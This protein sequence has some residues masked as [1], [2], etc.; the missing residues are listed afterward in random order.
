VPRKRSTA[1]RVAS[2]KQTTGTTG[3][4]QRIRRRFR[5]AGGCRDA[6]GFASGP[7]PSRGRP[8]S[9]KWPPTRPWSRSR[10]IPGR[11]QC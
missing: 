8:T 3:P 7:G 9:P 5:C 4:K 10:A 1:A 2:A 11:V 6:Q